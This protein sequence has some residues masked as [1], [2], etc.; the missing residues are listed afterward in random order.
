MNDTWIDRLEI[1]RKRKEISEKEIVSALIDIHGKSHVKR[2]KDGVAQVLQFW[3]EADGTPAECRQFCLEHFISN[4]KALNLL[5]QRTSQYME[6]YF[7][8]IGEIHRRLQMYI[9]LDIGQATSIDEMFYGFNVS[10]NYS[11]NV[12][13]IKIAFYILLNFRYYNLQELIELGDKLTEKQW[14]ETRLARFFVNRIPT[15]IKEEVATALSHSIQYIKNYYIYLG[16]IRWHNGKHLFGGKNSREKWQSHWEILG[17]LMGQY[18]SRYG[19]SRQKKLYEVLIHIIDQTI[20][21]TVINNPKVIWRIADNT[22]TTTSGSKILASTSSDFGH[23]HHLL[24]YF[25]AERKADDYLGTTFLERSFEDHMGIYQKESMGLLQSDVEK[26]MKELLYAPVMKDVAKIMRKILKRKLTAFDIWYTFNSSWQRKSNVL[27][28]LTASKYPTIQDFSND[29]P[30][31]LIKLGYPNDLA[32]KIAQNIVVDSA[33]DSGHA[34]PL[35]W[36]AGKVH[37][38][39]YFDKNGLSFSD[40]S[41][42]IHELGHCVEMYLSKYLAKYFSLGMLPNIAFSEAFAFL[43]EDQCLSLLELDKKTDNNEHL[44]TLNTFIESFELAGMGLLD[45]RIWQTM[46]Q[47]PNINADELKHIVIQLAIEIWNEY[48]APIFKIS[49]SPILATYSHFITDPLYLS[50]YFVGMIIKWQIS[51]FLIGKSLSEEMV[52]MCSIG[53]ITPQLWMRRAVGA[54]IS[55]K[56]LIEATKLAV[57]KLKQKKSA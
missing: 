17:E 22:V 33:R 2:I 12:F 53:N 4:A 39:V 49:N 35:E 48:F 9:D 57:Q 6:D 30:N 32:N 56:P 8:L 19:L 7:G 44:H 38:R 52:R 15:P 14:A 40:Y 26:L 54:D 1:I 28:K 25:N 16:K 45:I 55:S 3:E 36:R 13:S 10:T 51:Q 29:I 11:E 43:F 20:P 31:I 47:N 34:F 18:E 37:L 46:Y 42:A 27:D 21:A 50:N 41:V 24:R 5:F 23:Y